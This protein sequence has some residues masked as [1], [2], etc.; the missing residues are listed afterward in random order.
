MKV[1]K[2]RGVAGA[3][4]PGGESGEGGRGQ[5]GCSSVCS[6]IPMPPPPPLQ[7]PRT[8]AQGCL[9]VGSQELRALEE[10]S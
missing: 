1:G 2:R 5:R 7:L 3:S 6:G 4:P 9:S 10:G 8:V